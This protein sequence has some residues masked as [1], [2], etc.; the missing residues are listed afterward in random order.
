MIYKDFQNL[1][2]SALGFG[3]MRLPVM[4]GD[5]AKIDEAAT[6]KM[7][8]YAMEHGVNYYD[9]AWGY[10]S[11]NSER[12][13]G[14]ALRRYPRESF[15]LADKFP[16]YDLSNI[17]RVAVSYTHLLLTE[18]NQG[19]GMTIL[20]IEQKMDLLSEFAKTLAVMENG[21]II[22]HDTVRQVLRQPNLLADAG[23]DIP[24]AASLSTRLADR[25]ILDDSHVCVNVAE[26]AALILSLIHI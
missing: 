18:L 3:A 2:L 7:V 17:D 8:S 24:R 19:H 16:G 13:L 21:R 5:D 1:K 14:N 23:I 6:E 15:Y 11:G 9:T 4:D 20:V 22:C 25:G 12:V 10:H 26:A